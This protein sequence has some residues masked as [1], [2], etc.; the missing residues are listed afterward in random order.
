MRKRLT[1]VE[2]LRLLGMLQ[3][4]VNRM[5]SAN[6]VV[7]TRR[8]V[9]INISAYNVHWLDVTSYCHHLLP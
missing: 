9:V 5:S 3:L 7:P 1:R 4:A 2:V 6:H 8:V